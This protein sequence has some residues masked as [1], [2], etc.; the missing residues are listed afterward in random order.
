ME[1]ATD[2][3]TIRRHRRRR[4]ADR[5]PRGI[6]SHTDWVCTRRASRVHVCVRVRIL[7]HTATQHTYTHAHYVE[8]ENPHA[9]ILA[10]GS[11]QEQR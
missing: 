6:V 7:W 4:A 8:M 1:S 11:G 9:S 2:A 10:T 3:A 5:F